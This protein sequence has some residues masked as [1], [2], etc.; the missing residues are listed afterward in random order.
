M[1]STVKVNFGLL[2][3]FISVLKKVGLTKWENKKSSFNTLKVS[4][5]PW[6]QFLLSFPFL[7][8]QK[9]AVQDQNLLLT[10]HFIS[11]FVYFISPSLTFDSCI[12]PPPSTFSPPT[13]SPN[14]PHPAAC[15]RWV[16]VPCLTPL[17]PLLPAE[18]LTGMQKLC[19]SLC[20]NSVGSRNNDSRPTSPF[21]HH[22]LPHSQ[23]K[24]PTPLLCAAP[25]M[26]THHVHRPLGNHFLSRLHLWLWIHDSHRHP[27]RS[28]PGP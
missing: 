11:Y 26:A 3:L 16:F 21:R 1:F 15:S 23:G 6:T 2:K 4:Q 19:S 27:K 24:G 25:N 10:I 5:T 9:L 22:F 28:K 18:A 7:P 14:H 12:F 8:L 20:S 13:S 17:H